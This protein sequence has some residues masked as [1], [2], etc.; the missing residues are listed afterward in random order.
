VAVEVSEDLPGSRDDISISVLDD[1]PAFE[2]RGVA[3]V[4]AARGLGK[5]SHIL[6]QRHAVS[7]ATPAR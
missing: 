2:M 5:T 1:C 4:V 7:P 6:T 3:V